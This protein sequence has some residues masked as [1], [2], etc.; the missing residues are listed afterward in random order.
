[1]SNSRNASITAR[2]RLAVSCKF[3]PLAIF[4]GTVLSGCG[5]PAAAELTEDGQEIASSQEALLPTCSLGSVRTTLIQPGFTSSIPQKLSSLKITARNVGTVP[6]SIAGTVEIRQ[7]GKLV[8]TETLP[9]RDFPKGF[10][11]TT[12]FTRQYTLPANVKVCYGPAFTCLSL[13]VNS[14]IGE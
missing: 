2:S 12:K 5:A 6:C 10:S 13:T 11:S 1:M 4:C 7:D 9:A 8:A 3:L 14:P